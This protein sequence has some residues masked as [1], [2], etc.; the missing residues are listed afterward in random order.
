MAEETGQAVRAALFNR[1]TEDATMK[2][3]FGITVGEDTLVQ[4]FNIMADPDP[5][6]PYQVD[7][8]ELHGVYKGIHLYFLDLWDTNEDASPVK[9]NQAIDRLK[10][11]LHEW[12]ITSD[13]DE[14]AGGLVQALDYGW[15]WMPTDDKLVLHYATMWA[16]FFGAKRDITNI[17]G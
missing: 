5:E 13:D 9:I 6:F 10:I 17:L 16:V 11:L 4:L 15:G 2:S 1:I 14:I 8:L 12:Q 7:K 3:V